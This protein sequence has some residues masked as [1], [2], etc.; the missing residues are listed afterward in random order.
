MC[1]SMAT[2]AGLSSLLPTTWKLQSHFQ[3]NSQVISSSPR[4]PLKWGGSQSSW[5]PPHSSL[6]EK[7]TRSYNLGL[8]ETTAW[9]WALL[10]CTPITLRG[11]QVTQTTQLAIIPTGLPFLDS[12][13]T[14]A[15]APCHSPWNI[16]NI[17]QDL[18]HEN[19]GP[20]PADPINSDSSRPFP[21]FEAQEQKAAAGDF[22]LAGTHTRLPFLARPQYH[23]H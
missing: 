17:E 18:S 13:T 2:L 6:F 12:D 5:S 20:L 15:K 8:A 21:L 16:R 4:T 14:S 1:A 22:H 9:C 7:F 3:H 10:A 19:T 11:P 23:T